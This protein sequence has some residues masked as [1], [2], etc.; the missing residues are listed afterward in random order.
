MSDVHLSTHI[1]EAVHMV[2]DSIH[3]E[4]TELSLK[5]SELYWRS[6]PLWSLEQVHTTEWSPT[7]KQS[8]CSRVHQLQMPGTWSLAMASKGAA[9]ETMLPSWDFWTDWDSTHITQATFGDSLSSNIKHTTK[10]NNHYNNASTQP[11]MLL[12]E[13][14]WMKQS[15]SWST[16]TISWENWEEIVSYRFMRGG[17]NYE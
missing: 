13:R 15:I 5:V 7:G 1:A 4:S 17:I 11:K 10:N 12:F 9:G 14:K 2:M 6:H 3:N 16:K 8:Y